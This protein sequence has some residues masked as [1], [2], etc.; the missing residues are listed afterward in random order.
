MPRGRGDEFAARRGREAEFAALVGDFT[1]D[2]AARGEGFA[3][4]FAGQAGAVLYNGLGRYEDAF[5]AVHEAVDVASYP[6]MSP[7]SA[8]VELVESVHPA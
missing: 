3:L 4:A 7:Q 5:A 6:E 8:V 2:A 1:R